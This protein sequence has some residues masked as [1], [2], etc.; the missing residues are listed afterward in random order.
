MRAKARSRGRAYEWN[1]ALMDLGATI[2]TSRAPKC[3]L[4]P[5]QPDCAAAPVDAARV[6][7][8]RK[9]KTQAKS[10]QK[11]ASIR[12][13]RRFARGRIVDRLR[14]L[15]RPTDIVLDLHAPRSRMTR[16]R[17]RRRPDD[18]R[19]TRSRR[20]VTHDGNLVAL[21]E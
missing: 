9:A 13:H 17:R 14:E 18:R 12:T 20:L 3:L 16:V 6:A 5:L 21:R 7:M 19:G 10:P 8:A 15:P 2:C 11:R 4:C 1:S